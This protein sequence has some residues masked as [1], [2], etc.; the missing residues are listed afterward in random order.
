MLEEMGRD[1]ALVRGDLETHLEEARASRL[2]F[3]AGTVIVTPFLLALGAAISLYAA[4]RINRNWYISYSSTAHAVAAA[5]VAAVLVQLFRPKPGIG[6]TPSE[7]NSLYLGAGVTVGLVVLSF[8]T[9]ISTSHPGLFWVVFGVGEIVA[10]GYVGRAYSP[11]ES[12][13]MGWFVTNYDPDGLD[14]PFTLRDNL[15]RT[16]YW[17]GWML[18]IPSFVFEAYADV[19]GS[20]WAMRGPTELEQQIAYDVIHALAHGDLPA[21]RRAAERSTRVVR[22][23]H[24]AELVNLTKRGLQLSSDGLRLVGLKT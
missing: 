2:M 6:R 13:Y 1:A 24:E 22:V 8:G 21:A 4:T 11:R 23:L 15:D 18:A 19:F 3:V 9:R 10:L 17:T 7:W 20:G 12:Y 16:D 5:L 14:N